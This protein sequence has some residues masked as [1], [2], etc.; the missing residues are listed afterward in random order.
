MKSAEYAESV[1]IEVS[2]NKIHL[3]QHSYKFIDKLDNRRCRQW[4]TYLASEGIDSLFS[5]CRKLP[6]AQEK[7][8]RSIKA[9]QAGVKAN[10]K[11]RQNKKLYATAA[12]DLCYLYRRTIRHKLFR[13]VLLHVAISVFLEHE[14]ENSKADRSMR[15]SIHYLREYSG[16]I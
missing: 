8:K 14:A 7:W 10:P 9:L 2:R 12:E 4:L 16:Y 3:P 15:E 11:A 5:A 13:F 6:G 1:F